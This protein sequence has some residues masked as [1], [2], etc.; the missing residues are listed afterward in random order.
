MKIYRKR[1]LLLASGSDNRLKQIDR[2]Y[3]FYGDDGVIFESPISP[4]LVIFNRGLLPELTISYNRKGGNGPTGGV[5]SEL[6]GTRLKPKRFDGISIC[7]QFAVFVDFLGETKL[8]ASSERKHF[9][10]AQV[11]T[12]RTMAKLWLENR[13]NIVN[14]VSKTNHSKSMPIDNRQR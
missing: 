2:E 12:D 1:D 13:L 7:V 3:I 14:E 5:H 10:C 4:D 9:E 11:G 8:C 6:D